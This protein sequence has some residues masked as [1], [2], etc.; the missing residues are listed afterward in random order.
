MTITKT[1]IT[2]SSLSATLFITPVF[3]QSAEG[4]LEE[5][6]VTAERRENSLQDFCL[7]YEVY[8]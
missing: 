8:I 1:V 2:L 7:V 4:V 3:A 5:I 6:T